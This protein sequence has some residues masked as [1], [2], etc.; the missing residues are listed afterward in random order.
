GPRNLFL[1]GGGGRRPDHRRL[2]WPGSGAAATAADARRTVGDQPRAS[3]AQSVSRR[4]ER[5]SGAALTGARE[6]GGV[7]SGGPAGEETSGS[8]PG[9]PG[10]GPLGWH[11]R[12]RDRRPRRYL[13]AAGPRGQREL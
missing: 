13:S 1:R 4:N 7:R 11:E 8:D 5:D 10:A 9:R 6:R 3:H 12:R 2:V